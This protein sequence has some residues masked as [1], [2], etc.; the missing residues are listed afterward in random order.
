MYTA[1]TLRGNDAAYRSAKKVALSYFRRFRY[2]EIRVVYVDSSEEDEDGEEEEG[3]LLLLGSIGGA[4]G[5]RGGWGMAETTATAIR[6]FVLRER[7]R[8]AGVGVGG[9]LFVFGLQNGLIWVQNQCNKLDT[10]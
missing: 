6:L 2:C 8:A 7:E 3:L 4:V 1:L 9:C 5:R 10:F